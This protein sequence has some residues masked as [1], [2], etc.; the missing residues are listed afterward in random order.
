MKRIVASLVVMLVVSAC[1]GCATAAK[2]AEDVISA[3]L[4]AS[5]QDRNEEAYS[6]L[7]RRSQSAMTLEDYTADKE[8]NIVIRSDEFVKRTTF[9]VKQ[10]DVDGDHARAEVEITEPDV[11]MIVKD[12]VGA[13]VAWIFDDRE[14]LDSIENEMEKK[15]SKGDIPMTTR[16]ACYNLVRED[17]TWK[18]DLEP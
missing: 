1:S 15:Y 8:D 14:E 9:E 10:V 18:V 13:F 3:Y 6:Y 11:K 5:F 2:D 17:G 16:L 7:S 12:L 4:D